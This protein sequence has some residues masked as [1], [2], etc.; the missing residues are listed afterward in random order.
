LGPS[1]TFAT[2]VAETLVASAMLRRNLF[3]PWVG[4]AC[5]IVAFPAA[6]A[7]I[8]GA[9]FLGTLL[10]IGIDPSFMMLPGVIASLFLTRW[11]MSRLNRW[12]IGRVP[13]SASLDGEATLVLDEAGIRYTTAVSNSLVDWR[14]ISHLFS[15]R[16][17]LFF[18]TGLSAY[19]VPARCFAS[20]EARK[21]A[22]DYALAH[23]TPEAR[24]RSS[25]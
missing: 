5:F 23:M 2:S 7:C 11:V 14:G 22:I 16:G 9:Y 17:M 13:G 12:M 4:L 18:A 3:P 20:P 21:A 24:Q 25:T 8:W 1:F 10:P 6:M 15:H 19:Y